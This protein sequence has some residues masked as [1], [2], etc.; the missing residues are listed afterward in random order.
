MGRI[1]LPA[2]GTAVGFNRWL[3]DGSKAAIRESFMRVAL[4]LA[5]LSMAT[6]I[7]ILMTGRTEAAPRRIAAPP[8]RRIDPE[9]TAAAAA[10]RW[11][12][13]A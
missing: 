2:G 1:A 6:T 12:D 10:D 11:Y 3:H 9:L 8:K 5:I 4:M 13:E 7:F